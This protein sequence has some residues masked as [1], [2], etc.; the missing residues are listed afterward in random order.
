M[1]ETLGNITTLPLEISSSCRVILWLNKF[2]KQTN[3]RYEFCLLQW[4]DKNWNLL[5]NEK[6]LNKI[7]KL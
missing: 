7:I 2:P 3:Q 4:K 1:H 5:Y 6:L